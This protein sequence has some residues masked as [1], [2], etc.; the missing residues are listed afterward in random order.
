M[1]SQQKKKISIKITKCEKGRHYSTW[2]GNLKEL[3]ANIY[4]DEGKGGGF[5]AFHK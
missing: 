5:L 2:Q 3:R 1:F 4:S